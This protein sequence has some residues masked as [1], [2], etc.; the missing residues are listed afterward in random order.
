MTGPNLVGARLIPLPASARWRVRPTFPS[1]W[2]RCVRPPPVMLECACERDLEWIWSV[3]HSPLLRGAGRW[4]SVV[5]P[6]VSPLITAANTR[7]WRTRGFEVDQ[8]GKQLKLHFIWL[9]VYWWSTDKETIS[10]NNL[11]LLQV[12]LYSNVFLLINI[13]HTSNVCKCL[14]PQKYAISQFSQGRD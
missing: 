5:K 1:P 6:A 14:L 13:S 3:K 4:N 8:T 12:F 10:Y 9:A 7:S 2:N 11:G